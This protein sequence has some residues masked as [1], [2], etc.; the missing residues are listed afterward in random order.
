M[1]S[2]EPKVGI[3][4]PAYNA[5]DKIVISLESIL[6][7]TYKNIEITVINDGSDLISTEIIEE[8]CKVRN[9]KVITHSHNIGLGKTYDEIFEMCKEDY[10]CIYHADDIYDLNIVKKSV[11]YFNNNPNATLLFTD[12]KNSNLQIPKKYKIKNWNSTSYT[13]EYI[14]KDILNFS[15][16]LLTP[17]IC[18]R[19]SN[20][21][22]LKL[23][24]G[25]E[26]IKSELRQGN[27]CEDLVT[28]FELMKRGNVGI[29]PLPLMEW[30]KH[31]NQMSSKVKKGICYESD[32]ITVM[33]YYIKENISKFHISNRNL[34]RHRF[35]HFKD[36]IIA[37][38]NNYIQSDYKTSIIFLKKS[39][40]ILPLGYYLLY[41][42]LYII[43]K[44]SKWVL[45]L[46]ICSVCMS[47]KQESLIRWIKN[48]F[49]LGY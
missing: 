10:I 18:I 33:N 28:W 16:F 44:F 8:F 37:S 49:L 19:A 2:S 29:I 25:L 13:Y 45:I 34:C 14:F 9:I 22:I 27:S 24:F 4:V 31:E 38:I 26:N 41:F 1:Y 20:L 21:K 30:S 43:S 3:Y 23:T 36:C 6:K 42:D 46:F 48:K 35:F 5:V 17:S 15:N 39:W 7:Q 12:T 40:E 32:Y 11:E 47:I